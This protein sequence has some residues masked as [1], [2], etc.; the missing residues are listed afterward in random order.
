MSCDDSNAV[1]VRGN[2]ASEAKGTTKDYY[3]DSYSHYGIHMEMLKDYHRTT[4][5]RDAIWKNAYMFKDKVV[6]DVG[7]GT[8][9]LSMFAARAGARKVI[10]VDC[11][12]VAVQAQE[13]VKDNGFDDVITIIQ[14]KVE[15]L[16]LDEKVDIII[17]EWMG[18]F[19]LYESMLNTVLYA[20]DRWGTPDV[21]ILPDRANMY[22]CGIKDPQYKET[23]F[24]VWDNVLGLDFSYFKRLSYIEPFVDTVEQDQIIT[25]IVQFFSFHINTVK[26]EDL[27]FVREFT[28]VARCTESLDAISVHFDTPFGAGHELVVL[29]TSPLLPPTHWQQTV[30]FLYHPLQMEK[31]EKAVFT[32]SCMPNTGNPRDLD[33]SLHVDFDGALQSC[34]YDQ[35]FRLR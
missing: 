15:D 14:G 21:K 29:E 31:G 18:Y 3:F 22:A 34:H 17:S 1:A 13:I 23:K 10:G 9:I 27:S 19:L 35:E 8:G 11:S 24:N 32:I 16:N 25:D 33:I 26:E 30:L 6:L 5:Y 2:E 4:S 28:L 12:S 7:C 20:R